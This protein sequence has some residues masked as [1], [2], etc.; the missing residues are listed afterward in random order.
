[1]TK[2]AKPP[3]RK[4]INI[5][6]I[7]KDIGKYSNWQSVVVLN[8]LVIPNFDIKPPNIPKNNNR[9]ILR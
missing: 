5:I 2:L 9:N 8:K 7:N 6:D 4:V 3:V 1:M